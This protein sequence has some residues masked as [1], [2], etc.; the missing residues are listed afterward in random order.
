MDSRYPI[1]GTFELTGRCNLNCK[2][3]YVHVDNKRIQEFGYRER[4]AAEWIDM[5]RQVFDAGTLKLLLTGGEPMMRSDFCEIYEAIAQMGF[6]LTLY[7]NATIVTD[8][9]MEVLKRFPPH[10]IGITI[11]G[12]STETYQKVCGDSKAYERMR[13]G[14]ERLM[15]LP[16]KMELRTTIVQDNLAEAKEIEAFIKSYGD[17][18]TF[19]VNQTVFQSGRGSIGD[20]ASCRLTPEQNAKFYCNRYCD[21]AEEYVRDPEKLTE[22]RQVAER[23][24]DENRNQGEQSSTTEKT[25]LFYGCHAGVQEYTVTW[26]GRL[27]PCTM[28]GNC[29]TNPFEEGFSVAWRRLENVMV[30]P[31]VPVKCQECNVQQFCGA[32]TASR[33][34]ETGDINGVPKYFCQLAEAYNRILKGKMEE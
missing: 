32:C 12:L 4:T 17:R 18:V 19:N 24:R 34:C 13:E 10:M 31:K 22:L 28:M 3:C 26:D 33:Y 25:K 11:Y 7:T 16:S 29:F 15:T 23:K 9:V 8:Q 20:A 14:M 21:M 27:L 1:N 5:A 30:K 2:M 6:F